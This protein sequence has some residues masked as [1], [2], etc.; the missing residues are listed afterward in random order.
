MQLWGLYDFILPNGRAFREREVPSQ[1][2]AEM[3]PKFWA[4]MYRRTGPDHR[5]IIALPREE[6]NREEAL[7]LPVRSGYSIPGLFL[8]RGYDYLV[9]KRAAGRHVAGHLRVGL[10]CVWVPT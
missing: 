10:F 7:F 8:C 6:Y 5:L 3:C 1:S 9:H 4:T 2:A